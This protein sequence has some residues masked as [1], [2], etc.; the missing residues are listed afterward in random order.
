MIQCGRTLLRVDGSL[1]EVMS[2]GGVGSERE[3]KEEALATLRGL[4][5]KLY[6]VLDAARDPEIL[7]LLRRSGYRYESLWKGWAGEVYGD[8]APY[9]VRLRKDGRLL[10]Q[11]VEGL[12]RGV[13]VYL[14]SYSPFGT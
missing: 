3:P 12:G 11:L 6:A 8:V 2:G 1:A 4:P 14:L 7:T 5:G 9:L 10:E 13:G